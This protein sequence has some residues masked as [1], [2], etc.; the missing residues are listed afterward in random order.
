MLI[1]S[2][3][4]AFVRFLCLHKKGVILKRMKG[5]DLVAPIF[6]ESVFHFCDND[7]HPKNFL[8]YRA[9]YEDERS[10]GP[11]RKVRRDT[12]S[13]FVYSHRLEEKIA[14]KKSQQILSM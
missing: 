6:M 12:L 14:L 13:T 7:L 2:N 9:L 3:I 8:R 11:V 10:F 5:V 4:D 1:L